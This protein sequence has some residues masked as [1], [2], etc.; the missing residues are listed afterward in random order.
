MYSLGIFSII[1]IGI[2]GAIIGYFIGKNYTG[3]NAVNWQEQYETAEK[4]LA[5]TTKQLKKERKQ[6][7]QMEQ[8]NGSWKNKH[9]ELSEKYSNDKIAFEKETNI[10][11]EELNTQKTSFS[12]LDT[13]YSS[14][15][16]QYEKLKKNHQNLQE[17]YNTDLAD[18]KGWKNI[19][20]SLESEI[21]S[22]KKKI[23]LGHQK[24]KE[25]K[26]TLDKQ[27][28]R[29][30]EANKFAS[31]FRIM[32]AEKRRL[33]KDL[34]YWEKKHYDT[35][36]EL[37]SLKAEVETMDATYKDLNLRFKGSLIEKENMLK[38][39][40]EFK[41]KFVNANNLYHELKGQKN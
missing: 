29:I 32:R 2:V 40:E 23:L 26:E 30:N 4:E 21:E 22:H 10:L 27:T 28:N 1:L 20:S 14:L 9:E 13:S 35:H 6:I 37:A 8:Q 5:N 41:T 36:H 18:T 24:I 19:K 3:K 31:D 11:K 34:A 25:L 33:T 39:L 16:N 38:K 17:K 12:K 7:Q 15:T